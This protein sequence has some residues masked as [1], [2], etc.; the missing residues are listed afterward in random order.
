MHTDRLELL[1]NSLYCS[2]CLCH[3]P[4]YLCHSP[5]C[6]YISCTKSL[7]CSPT[8][9]WFVVSI[10]NSAYRNTAYHYNNDGNMVC[11]Q[12][13]QNM[14]V[15]CKV[16]SDRPSHCSIT[17]SK[18]ICKGIIWHTICK[19]IKQVEVGQWLRPL[20]KCTCVSITYIQSMYFCG[21]ISMSK[22]KSVFSRGLS[23][24]AV[25]FPGL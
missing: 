14:K 23:T 24:C 9:H 12:F 21:P 11:L 3:S 13:K 5:I 19:K 8:G 22:I 2:I 15:N 18:L 20:L 1:T 16:D 25:I 17:Y 7:C 6:L 10:T 4:I